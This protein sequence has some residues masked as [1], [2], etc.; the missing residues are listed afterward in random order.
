MDI[1]DEQVTT[2]RVRWEEAQGA[3]G[4]MLLYSAINATE[5]SVEQEVRD[6]TERNVH[7]VQVHEGTTSHTHVCLRMEKTSA[8]FQ[9]NSGK[10]YKVTRENLQSAVSDTTQMSHTE[11]KYYKAASVCFSRSADRAEKQNTVEHCC[12]HKDRV[13]HDLTLP[14][15]HP[16]AS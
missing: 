10:H 1:Y 11:V 2:M 7:A 13:S 12:L 3:T 6:F 14:K 15:G 5:P 8:R 4:Y 16:Y 9:R